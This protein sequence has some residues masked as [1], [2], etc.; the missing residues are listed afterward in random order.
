MVSTLLHPGLLIIACG[1]ALGFL[2]GS[3]RS[4]LALG[5]PLAAIWLVLAAPEGARIG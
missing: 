3:L 5:V 1:V 4:A 2:R